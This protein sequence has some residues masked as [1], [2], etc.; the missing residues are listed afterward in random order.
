MAKRFSPQQRAR[1]LDDYHSG[2]GTQRAFCEAHRISVATLS[3]W[4]RKA[5]AAQSA[6]GS[7]APPVVEIGSPKLGA[8]DLIA[9][10]LPSGI[11]IRC[12]ATQTGLILKQL[13]LIVGW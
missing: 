11:V 12:H 3:N 7:G 13:G 6:P 1:L 9:I 10:E 5:N 8:S 2:G 4:L